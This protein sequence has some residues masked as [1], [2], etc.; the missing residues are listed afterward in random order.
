MNLG[1]TSFSAI[2]PSN[3]A[4]TQD[5]G[6]VWTGNT[7]QIVDG[8]FS[9]LDYSGVSFN[10]SVTAMTET[11]PNIFTGSCL[12]DDVFILSADTLDFTGRTIWVDNPEITR[13]N[14]LIVSDGAISGY[15]LKSDSEG[16]ATWQVDA[17][18]STFTG[19]TSA[20]C[21]SDIYVS[22][23]HSCSPLYINRFNQPKIWSW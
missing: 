1:T 14:K 17:S 23:I 3:S 6:N 20:T 12:S 11:S 5:S 9:Y 2:T 4:I 19:N 15:V 10:L 18:G 13:T 8:N 21:I 7:S 16:M 22:N